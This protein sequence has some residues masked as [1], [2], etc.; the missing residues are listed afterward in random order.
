M[1]ES[2]QSGKAHPVGKRKKPRSSARGGR[3][4]LLENPEDIT[5]T[6]EAEHAEAVRTAAKGMGISASAL[7]RNM[8]ERMP[9][10]LIKTKARRATKGKN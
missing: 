2:N 6:V 7:I 8:I 5:F 9:L 3:P 10:E 1:S 4:R